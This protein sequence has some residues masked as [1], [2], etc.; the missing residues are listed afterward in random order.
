MR[1]KFLFFGLILAVCCTPVCAQTVGVSS[2]NDFSTETPP[3]TISVKLMEPLEISETKSLQTGIILKGDLVDVVSPKR[4]KKD[5]DFSFQPTSYVDENGK[6]QDLKLNIKASYTVPMDKGDM[7]KKA[8]L[9]VGNH[10]VS[11]LKMG[12]AAVEGAVK[13]ENENRFKSSVN[14]VYEAS[15]LSLAKKGEDL[16]IKKNQVFFL[17]FPSGKKIEKTSESEAKQGQNYSY[18]IEKE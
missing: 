9:S 2:L 1:Q 7:A 6:I 3:K 17:K 12:Y 14:S 10:F 18:T 16:Y 4:L 15:P 8:A 11:G 5:A 13:N